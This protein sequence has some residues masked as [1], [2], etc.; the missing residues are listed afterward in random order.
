M[1]RSDLKMMFKQSF[2]PLVVS[3]ALVSACGAQENI[4]FSGSPTIGSEAVGTWWQQ[5][6]KTAPSSFTYA[7]GPIQGVSNV[8]VEGIS[9]SP[10]TAT[11]GLNNVGYTYDAPATATTLT[12]SA[13][14][15]IPASASAAGASSYAGIW[16]GLAAAP[17]G[18][19]TETPLLEFEGPVSPTGTAQTPGFYGFNNATGLYV[20]VVGLPAADATSGGWFKLTV[21]ISPALGAEYTVTDGTNNLGSA[22]VPF[23]NTASSTIRDVTLMGYITKAST[24]YTIDW[25]GLSFNGIPASG[26]PYTDSLSS[27]GGVC[28]GVY[29]GS[30]SGTVTV[31][32][33]ATCILDAATVNGVINQSGGS[34]LIE[35]GSI[36][37]GSVNS[38][39]GEFT[40]TGSNLQSG[41]WIQGI[42]AGAPS[43]WFCGDTFGGNPTYILSGNGIVFGNQS[44]GLTAGTTVC[45]GNTVNA[46]VNFQQNAGSDYIDGNAVTGSILDSGNNGYV[47][48]SGNTGLNGGI[49]VG[50]IT[51]TAGV[52]IV[53]N[54]VGGGGLYL[55]YVSGPLNVTSNYIGGPAQFLNIAGATSFVKDQTAGSVSISGITG[56]LL[57]NQYSASGNVNIT[58]NSGGVT[59]ENFNPA[60]TGLTLNVSSNTGSVSV[61]GDGTSTHGWGTINVNS[62]NINN[63]SLAVT[64]N[65]ATGTL[66]VS[67]NVGV[68]ST[69]ATT[70]GNTAGTIVLS[71]NH[72]FGVNGNNGLFYNCSGSFIGAQAYLCINWLLYWLLALLGL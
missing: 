44:V 12:V 25:A 45:A 27:S 20:P 11:P 31:V 72:T 17:G 42:P 40:A 32:K 58:G 26:T 65:V 68:P 62:N 41:F 6:N 24:N 64:G 14:V 18:N 2:L 39:G 21:S 43:D 10:N 3:M 33:G 59:V 53:N 70:T 28:N 49:G 66:S 63:G 19:R 54:T 47:E 37:S 1:R 13:S 51:G 69:G 5:S 52:N 71:G 38:S 22:W 29:T 50:Q 56:G 30:Y 23:F 16:G 36:V 57:V 67:N 4:S 61:T 48:I 8:L 46:N 7:A 9:G 35:G 55:N 34:L 60:S 15:Y